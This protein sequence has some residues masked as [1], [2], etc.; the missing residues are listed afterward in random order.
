MAHE[1]TDQ[2]QRLV[3]MVVEP[4]HAHDKRIGIDIKRQGTSNGLQTVSEP[5]KRHRVG[6]QQLQ[7]EGQLR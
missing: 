2:L 1:I 3:Q 5:L 6:P 4:C 7:I